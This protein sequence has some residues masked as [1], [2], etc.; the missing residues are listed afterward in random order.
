VLTNLL[1][2]PRFVRLVEQEAIDGISVYTPSEFLAD[3]RKGVWKE[4]DAPQVKID[5]YRRNLQRAYL[6][7]VN[8]KLNGAAPGIPANLQQGF[9][10]ATR[11]RSIAPS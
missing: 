5:A 2:S 3:V 11:S 10:A 1:S 8:G 9:P 4:L 7:L 6:D